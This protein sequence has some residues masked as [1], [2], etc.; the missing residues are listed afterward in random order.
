MA[1]EIVAK[2]REE[3]Q[4]HEAPI[5]ELGPLPKEPKDGDNLNIARKISTDSS[6][7]NH[8]PGFPYFV[9]NIRH[10]PPHQSYA[11]SLFSAGHGYPMYDA[12]TA[13][14]VP[15]DYKN[16][17]GISIGD[18]GILSTNGQFIFAFNIFLPAGHPY[19]KGN[20]PDSFSPL[21][22][23]DE[24]E[25]HTVHEYFPPGA[26]VAS[27]GIK[28]TRHSEN[29]LHL[30]FNSTERV[31][32]LL[33]LPEG[34]TRQDVATDRIHKYVACNG[35]EW[36]YFFGDKRWHPSSNGSTYV[37]TGVDKTTD[38]STMSFQVRLAVSPKIL[39]R[40]EKKALRGSDGISAVRN[41]FVA[42]PP[43]RNLCVFLRGIRIGVGRAEWIENVEE[44]PGDGEFAAP[45]TEIY[46]PPTWI[47]VM[48]AK[49]AFRLG[50]GHIG[51]RPGVSYFSHPFHPSDIIGPLMLSLRPDAPLVL[52]DDLIGF[53][54]SNQNPPTKGSLHRHAPLTFFCSKGASFKDC[55]MMV[56]EF[57][58]YYDVVEH[59]GILRLERNS[60]ERNAKVSWHTNI[61]RFFWPMYDRNWASRGFTE[62]VRRG[63]HHMET[64]LYLPMDR[65]R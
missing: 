33:V 3:I 11:R 39:A 43:S 8:F 47:T 60:K 24:S 2:Q 54:D 30:S 28:V 52:I 49:L 55:R 21:E 31:G 4:S 56:K 53:V 12:S 34:A 44:Q 26:V 65:A 42:T 29:P 41:A 5:Q 58:E 40:Y 16:V 20:T 10:F 51:E 17:R 19:N 38:C 45:Y 15:G 64:N 46:F 63:Q 57:F 22:P 9:R 18:V 27:K 13:T 6:A 35:A 50:F 25:I 1:E 48:K 32:G 23:L 36:A 7:I 61:R 14:S 59:E 62:L 37:I